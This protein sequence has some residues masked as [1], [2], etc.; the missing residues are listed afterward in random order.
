MFKMLKSLIFLLVFFV[1]SNLGKAREVTITVTYNNVP[2]NEELTTAWGISV[3][4]EGLEKSMLFDTGGDGAVLLANMGKL[5]INPYDIEIVVLSH[6]HGDHVG[7]LD[8]LLEKNNNVSVCIPSSF[9]DDFK[10]KVNNST[11]RLIIVE[12]PYKICENVWTTGELGAS[13]KEQSLV[14]RTP[15]GLIIVNGCSHP[16]IDNIVNFVKNHFE[17]NIYL[18]L[19]GFHLI[20]YSEI[21]VKEIIKKLKTLKVKKIAPSHCTGGKAI[22]LF[23]EAWGENF[24][25]LGCGARIKV[26]LDNNGREKNDAN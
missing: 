15:K 4:I 12:E 24:I 6:I 10:N 26:K 14:I 22:E 19:G 18:V 8:A 3:F 16:G 1:F 20:S 2:F 23:E 7:G 25:E 17:E 21:E 13:I 9:P 11:G 5:G